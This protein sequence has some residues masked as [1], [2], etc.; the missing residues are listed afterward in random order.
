[1]DVEEETFCAL[2]EAGLQRVFVGVESID[3]E[4]LD[5][6][7]KAQD[8]HLIDRAIEILNSLGVHVE[9]GFILFTPWS[10]LDSLRAKRRFLENF[11]PGA[12]A[13]LGSYLS[14]MPGTDI[15]PI[16]R[17][18]SLLCGEWPDYGFEFRDQK[19]S[20]LFGLVN[21]ELTIPWTAGLQRLLGFQWSQ[22]DD[23][24]LRHAFRRTADPSLSFLEELLAWT[25][26]ARLKHFDQF[27]EIVDSLTLP[28]DA[29]HTS[30]EI[31]TTLSEASLAC[32]QDAEELVAFLNAFETIANESA[33]TL[34]ASA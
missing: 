12:T 13:S 6:F 4:E 8:R 22:P 11:G 1:M 23:W 16:L 3:Q 32:Q 34:A 27:F 25:A 15:E 21:R 2:V 17:D 31:A 33:A 18:Q 28:H 19:A 24:S 10:T 26:E 14:V 20:I 5:Y 29:D 9:I 7:R 30:T